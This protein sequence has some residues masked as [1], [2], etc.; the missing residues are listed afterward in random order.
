MLGLGDLVVRDRERIQQRTGG[1]LDMLL[2]DLDTDVRYEV[3][4]QLGALDADHIVRVMQYWNR[5]RLRT[6]Q[7]QH[8][9]VLIAE[10]IGRF[11][12]VLPSSRKGF[13]HGAGRRF[14]T[15]PPILTLAL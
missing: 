15:A 10:E 2:E 14:P 7:V 11:A 3:E 5:E 8:R 13:W 4:V 9:A 6:P 1:Y 12:D